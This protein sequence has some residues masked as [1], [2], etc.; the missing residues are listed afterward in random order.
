MKR[1]FKFFAVAIAA[2]IITLASCEKNA[3]VQ[4]SN[5]SFPSN[6]K[7]EARSPFDFIGDIHN[8]IMDQVGV[9]M[10]KDLEY[11]ASLQNPT[12]D[13]KNKMLNKIKTSLGK[14]TV[15]DSISNNFSK[16]IDSAYS[17]LDS[18]D[19]DYFLKSNVCESVEKYYKEALDN[20]CT[21]DLYEIANYGINKAWS[22]NDTLSTIF[23]VVMKYSAKYWTSASV[24]SSNPWYGIVKTYGEDVFTDNSIKGK[25]LKEKLNKIK[26]WVV[27]KISG[28][29]EPSKATVVIA[30][31]AA[32]ALIGGFG[33]GGWVSAI[34]MTV[35]CS[36]GAAVN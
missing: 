10:K 33:L 19:L 30:S 25:S 27:E 11:Y 8:Q 2:I 6:S 9:I 17:F 28:K 24:D 1:Y 26:D 4:S 13:D 18:F 20:G 12:E 3:D 16:N 32:G 31:D 23:F 7:A 35:I 22:K 21:E 29:Q 5:Q 15:P 14:V 36:A 34:A